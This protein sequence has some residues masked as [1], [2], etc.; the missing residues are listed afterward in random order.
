[1]EALAVEQGEGQRIPFGERLRLG[2]GIIS[3][4]EVRL[5]RRAFDAGTIGPRAAGVLRLDADR[6]ADAARNGGRDPYEAVALDVLKPTRRYRMALWVQVFL[7][8]DRPLRNAIEL[9]FGK[10]LES[11]RVVRELKE[12]VVSTVAPMIGEDAARNLS[13]LLETRHEAVNAEIDAIAVQYPLYASRLEE[14]LISRASVRRER[15]QYE[16]LLH[17]GVVGQEL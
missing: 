10:L 7:R 14:N 1:M 6:L 3:G 8:L 13:A 11:E 17:D 4:Q 2:L 9:H 16:R 5:I 15:E 12:F